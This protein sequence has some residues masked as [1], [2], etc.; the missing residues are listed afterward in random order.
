MTIFLLFI[1]L[2]FLLTIVGYYV[3]E[4]LL[5]IIG[6]LIFGLISVPLLNN[7]LEYKTGAFIS[8]D[9]DYNGT[10]LLS[11]DNYITYQYESYTDTRWY[12]I[13]FIFISLSGLFMWYS[14]YKGATDEDD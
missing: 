11:A 2:A 8:S 4:N 5:I 12:G 9:Y 10:Q 14:G 1:A 13:F 3:K 7:N 6:F